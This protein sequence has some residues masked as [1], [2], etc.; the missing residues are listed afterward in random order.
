M[1]RTFAFVP[2]FILPLI[3]TPPATTNAPEE[4]LIEGVVFIIF[5]IEVL[6]KP[7]PAGPV[8]PKEPG[9]PAGPVAPGIPT[10]VLQ[11]LVTNFFKDV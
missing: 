3:P 10:K 7:G 9:G 4:L 11:L 2:I 8:G 5:A 6:E 1:P